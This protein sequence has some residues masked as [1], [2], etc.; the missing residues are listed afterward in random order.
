M[1]IAEPSNSSSYLLCL[2]S[3]IFAEFS[4]QIWLI[5]SPYHARAYQNGH[6]AIGLIVAVHCQRLMQIIRGAG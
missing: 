2:V 5:W 3:C 6:D 1:R 4:V